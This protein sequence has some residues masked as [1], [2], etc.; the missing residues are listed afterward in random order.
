MPFI[1]ILETKMMFHLQN[2]VNNMEC[3]QAMRQFM[4]KERQ[5]AASSTVYR[6][7]NLLAHMNFSLMFSLFSQ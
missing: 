3:R 5:D 6:V 4:Q 7:L 1:C 2:M